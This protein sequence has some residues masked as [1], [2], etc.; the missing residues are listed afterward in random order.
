MRERINKLFYIPLMFFVLFTFV[1]FSILYFIF[2]HKVDIQI[3]SVE[4]EIVLRK[5]KRLKSDIEN[6]K[7]IFY[8]LQDTI[9]DTSLEIGKHFLDNLKIDKLIITREII[10][11]KI[12]KHK[13]FNYSVFQ[14]KYIILN[15]NGNNYIVFFKNIDKNIYIY[16]VNKKD[17]DDLI[18]YKFTQYLDKL[19]KNKISYYAMGKITSFNPSK[20]G[21]FGYIYYMPERLRYLQGLPLSINKPDVKRKYY[22]KEYFECLKENKSHC[23]ESYYFKNPKTGRYEEKI[24]DISLIKGY[25][26]TIVKGIYKSQIIAELHNKINK[27]IKTIREFLLTAIG[28]Y[29]LIVS[30]AFLVYFKF[31]KNLR[32]TLLEEHDS[33][34]KEIER[35][36]YYDYLTSLPNRVKLLKDLDIKQ[37]KSL[38]I[39]DI[40]DFGMINELYGFDFGNEILK[41]IGKILKK[42]FKNIYKFGNDEFAVLCEEKDLS[43][44]I[45]DLKIL[46]NNL[47]I[48]DIKI[49]VNIGISTVK[50]YLENSEIAVYEAKRNNKL[51]VVFDEELKNK[52]KQKFEKIQFLKQVLE[53]KE[54]IP[55][56]QCIVDKN[57][58]I[59]KYEALMRIKTED[60]VYTPFYFMEE[61][62]A[63]K[64]YNLFSYNMILKV[65]EDIK[66]YQFNVSINLSYEDIVD[67]NIFNFLVNLEENI[68][69]YITFEI[70]ESENILNYQKLHEFIQIVREK[71]AKIAIDD[72]GSG[73]S[74][75]TNIIQI[76]PDIIKIDASLIKNLND[77]KT[78]KLVKFI[79]EFAKEYNIESVAEF[80]SD[81]EKFEILKSLDISCYQGYYF[82]KPLPV[83]EI[84]K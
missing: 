29:I 23:I 72:F 59:I 37:I 25:N 58:N 71:G 43:A 13:K 39:I 10:Y 62:K 30:I 31:L 8:L 83:E 36:Y 47:Y 76:N 79:V 80:V 4:K 42:R 74:N 60:N 51:I 28:I 65:I 24:S 27:Y 20:N 81:K 66:K 7:N 17:I 21:I 32:N 26:F 44:I 64:L 34:L 14:N 73:Y 61:I 15:F 78:F 84:F 50:P 38:A 48:K 53:K 35:K 56:Y 52:E 69:G 41:E 49:E 11:G 18:I 54:I 1:Y 67:V 46:F 40:K 19:N 68:L 3:K 12:P 9:Y 33:L 57:Q 45:Y 6:I 2:N 82:C 70:L 75:F 77:D 22:R 55:Y 16:G 5:I 63:A